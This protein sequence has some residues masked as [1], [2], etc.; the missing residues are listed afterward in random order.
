MFIIFYFFIS[1][2]GFSL[3]NS[4]N[5]DIICKDLD[6]DCSSRKIFC[7]HEA[8]RAVMILKCAKTCDACDEV[9]K[10]I[11][12]MEIEEEENENK[13]LPWTHG[14]GSTEKEVDEN[15]NEEVDNENTGEENE[16]LVK[17]IEEV[18]ESTDEPHST[19]IDNNIEEEKID[20]EL[21]NVEEDEDEVLPEQSIEDNK[22]IELIPEDEETYEVPV[23]T[24][25]TKTYSQFNKY[26]PMPEKILTG[27]IKSSTT[28][29]SPKTKSKTANALITR[30]ENEKK[31]R[32]VDDASDCELR[33]NLCN[34][35]KFGSIVKKVCKRTCGVCQPVIIPTNTYVPLATKSRN[36]VKSNNFYLKWKESR[37]TT[38]KPIIITMQHMKNQTKNNNK[39]TY[40]K[41]TIT[42]KVTSQSIPRNKNPYVNILSS[43][44]GTRG[45]TET[46]DTTTVVTDK[47]IDCVSKQ[48]LCNHKGYKNLMERM[49]PKTCAVTFS[50]Y[51]FNQ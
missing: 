20:E 12:E 51:S 28:T 50:Y 1:I 21:K 6:P 5:D 33:K 30:I 8:Y 24:V 7:D 49:C 48:A 34:D 31:R 4:F 41:K 2:N 10:M 25:K 46:T 15:N 13:Q 43:K 37:N 27:Q 39:N 19:M 16:E 32:C 26:R 44:Y 35:S 36:T 45:Q 42:K 23:T 22:E 18:V 38:P 11:E 40:G 47:A 9:N 17:E 29:K 14:G 3:S